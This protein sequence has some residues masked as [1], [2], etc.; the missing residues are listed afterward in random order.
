MITSALAATALLAS[1]A[2]AFADD[3]MMTAQPVSAVSSARVVCHHDGEIIQS[4]N[5]PV[6][7]HLKRPVS[8]V[9]FKSSDWYRSVGVRAAAT[10]N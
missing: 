10:N 9:Q 1:T 3:Q 8:G 5:G 2:F 4:Q 7:C 6:L